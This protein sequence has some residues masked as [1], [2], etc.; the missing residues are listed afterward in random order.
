MESLPSGFKQNDQNDPNFSPQL[1]EEVKR[2]WEM[3]DHWRGLQK[4]S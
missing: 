3:R 2:K 4:L 1:S